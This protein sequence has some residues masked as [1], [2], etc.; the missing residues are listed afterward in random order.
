ML[1]QTDLFILRNVWDNMDEL[2][3]DWDFENFMS[4]DDD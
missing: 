3:E 2:D 1:S 4:D